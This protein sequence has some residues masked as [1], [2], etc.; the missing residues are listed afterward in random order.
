MISR[1]FL[2]IIVPTFI[3][4]LQQEKAFTVPGAEQMFPEEAANLSKDESMQVILYR[5][6]KCCGQTIERS[7][8]STSLLPIFK[9]NNSCH[10]NKSIVQCLVTIIQEE[11]F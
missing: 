5:S 8:F 11:N 2:L 4:G 1:S 9:P 7:L 3:S 6:G 10:K